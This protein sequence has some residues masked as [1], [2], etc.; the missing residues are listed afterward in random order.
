[1]LSDR[2]AIPSSTSG[3]QSIERP[4]R[5]REERFKRTGNT[6]RVLRRVQWRKEG[7]KLVQNKYTQ[8]ALAAIL[9]ISER[10]LQEV[11]AG[12]RKRPNAPRF[13]Q[14][15][16]LAIGLSGRGAEVDLVLASEL[17]AL[18]TH[19]SDQE[20]ASWRAELRWLH[21]REVPGISPRSGQDL[22]ISS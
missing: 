21:E 10:N 20:L 11:E 3:G 8:K 1:M 17:A 12:Q 7:G 16:C 15:F 9:G 22:R 13:L 5:R 14:A 2:S 18:I 4:T 6:L 19:G